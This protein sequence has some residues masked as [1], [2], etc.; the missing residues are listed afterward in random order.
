MELADK[1]PV[2]IQGGS[3]GIH[4][5]VAAARGLSMST[6]AIKSNG[7]R[8][9]HPGLSLALE[10]P[11]RD[12]AVA[13][14]ALREDHLLLLLMLE[15]C[16][17][18]PDRFSRRETMELVADLF[19]AHAAICS[20][21]RLDG[22]CSLECLAVYELIDQVESTDFRSRLHAARSAT[23]TRILEVYIAKEQRALRR[24]V[25]PLLRIERS[26]GHYAMLRD[27]GALAS[28]ARRLLGLDG[29]ARA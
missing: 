16:R 7:G 20:Q 15:R 1:E 2:G 23:L 19:E 9:T 29:Q 26:Q 18:A 5:A 4:N 24:Q 17:Q 25:S 3:G 14:E 8:R 10:S 27:R 21:L 28:R 11:A 13:A 22:E 12:Y 6:E